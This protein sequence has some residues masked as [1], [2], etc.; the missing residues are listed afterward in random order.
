MSSEIVLADFF[1]GC[2]GTARGFADAGVRPAFATDWDE[3]AVQTFKLNSP[4]VKTVQRD[5]R[6]LGPHEVE[7]EA[8]QIGEHSASHV[9]KARG[10]GSSIPIEPSEARLCGDDVAAR[11]AA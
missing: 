9:D 11:N 1:S 7:S 6:H 4:D 2:G 8:R 10:S 3:E 5:I